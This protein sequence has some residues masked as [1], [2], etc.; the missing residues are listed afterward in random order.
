VSPWRAPDGIEPVLAARLWVLRED[1]LTLRSL[2]KPVIWPPDSPLHAQC[3]APDELR[4]DD[5]PAP[6]EACFC[7]VWA[8]RSPHGLEL[9]DWPALE[10]G[11]RVGGITK[12]WGR[13]VVGT[14][15]W[16]A[17]WARPAALVVPGRRRSIPVDL[18]R[19]VASRYGIHVLDRWPTTPLTPLAA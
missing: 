12:L 8:L 13:V 4:T 18:A 9:V 19:S 5:H 15:G 14:K 11:W 2:V 10:K 1:D 7:G 6:G 17:E 3:K 16:R